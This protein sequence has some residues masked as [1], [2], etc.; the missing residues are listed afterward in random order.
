MDM[1][2]PH[3]QRP[4]EKFNFNFQQ[5]TKQD[6]VIQKQE[7]KNKKQKYEMCKTNVETNFIKLTYA[8]MNMKIT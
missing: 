4:K 7:H 8:N 3:E 2:N 1:K 5:G 6:Y